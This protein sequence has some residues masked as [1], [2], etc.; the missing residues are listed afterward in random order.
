MSK[1]ADDIAGGS[2]RKFLVG[3][4]AAAGG[5]A[6]LSKGVSAA[7]G[8]PP[9]K[10]PAE[11]HAR[12][13]FRASAPAQ[14]L[15]SQLGPLKN[16]AGTWVGKGFNLISLPDFDNP[17]GPQPFR[18][19]LNATIEILEFQKNRWKRAQ[20]WLP[21]TG[22]INI[23]G[24]TYLQRVSDRLT[25]GA[26]HIE[27]GLWLHVPATTVP[28]LPATVVRQGSIPH[29]TS[30]L[31]Q[32]AVI[33]TVNGGPKIQPVDS[34]PFNDKG[35]I[36]NPTYLAPFSQATLPPGFLPPFLKNPNL[37]LEEAILGQNIVKTDVLLVSTKT[38]AGPLVHRRRS[39][40]HPVPR[41]QRQCD[42]ARCDVLDRDGSAAGRQPV[43][44]TAIHADRHLEL[45]RY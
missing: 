32:G 25:S 39:S 20:P 31:A 35:P 33:P 14:Q 43:H 26:M 41:Q 5:V 9:A 18:L 7:A 27:P 30:I 36:T 42:P 4:G 17:Q 10:A 6:V 19:K 22:D 11:S 2:S 12:R 38:S 15:L 28:G 8:Q 45:P 23:F 21:G 3:A 29:G 13:G 37:A 34:T 16:L 40:E 44:A 1:S 24:L